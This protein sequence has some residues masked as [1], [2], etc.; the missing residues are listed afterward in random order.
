MCIYIKNVDWSAIV[1]NVPE[2]AGNVSSAVKRDFVTLFYKVT[3][4]RWFFTRCV[5]F[6]SV[7]DGIDSLFLSATD[8]LAASRTRHAWSGWRENIRITRR[9]NGH[10]GGSRAKWKNPQDE[11]DPMTDQVVFPELHVRFLRLFTQRMTDDRQDVA[12]SHGSTSATSVTRVLPHT[13][14]HTLSS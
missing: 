1:V 2:T 4:R 14:P 8:W 6:P 13:P 3:D 7:V 11:S 9:E 5:N 12:R 10:C